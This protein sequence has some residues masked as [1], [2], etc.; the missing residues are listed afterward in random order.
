M[1]GVV[2]ILGWLVPLSLVQ[3][4]VVALAV[5]LALRA[6]PPDRARLRHTVAVG[7][8]ALT[9]A[10]FVA[11]TAI[12]LVDW[13]AHVACWSAVGEP[14][15]P[16]C[17]S[18]GVPA[19]AGATPGEKV[20]AVL[21]WVPWAPTLALPAQRAAA[22]AWTSVA[23][24]A[25]AVWLAIVVLLGLREVRLRRLLRASRRSSEPITDPELEAM[26]S[27]LR[28]DLRIGTR[29]DLRESRTLATPCVIGSVPAT[30]LLPA[31][32]RSA[33]DSEEIRGILAHE[34]GH[35]RWKD[36]R[37]H[38]LERAAAGLLFFNPFAAWMVRR[39]R[40]EREA[41]CDRLAAEVGSRSRA[42]YVRALLLLE[43]FRATPLPETRLPALF[44]EGDLASRVNRLLA[45]HAPRRARRPRLVG[46]ALAAAL[47]TW[48]LAHVTFAGSSLGS[49]AIMVADEHYGGGPAM[50]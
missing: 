44:G 3:G 16:G 27:G 33:L 25:G 13:S 6:L 11:T 19:P 34:L 43:G 39:A 4:A 23:W 12:L 38:G 47:L 49:W 31:G 9:A 42:G 35:V 8:L 37:T 26:L 5:W 41:A 32:L 21:N 30:I 50:P 15:S 36:A 14:V 2:R 10:T 18:H 48:T 45:E 24:T 28:D 29:V 40:E 46:L 20:R 17:R 1:T 22:R 7:G